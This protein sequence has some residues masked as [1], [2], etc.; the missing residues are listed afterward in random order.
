VSPDPH[1]G[2]VLSIHRARTSPRFSD[3]ELAAVA[4]LG[5]HVERSLRLS[6]RLFDAELLNVGLGEALARVDI[7]VFVI[8]SSG[9]VTL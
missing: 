1:L 8:D 5:R 3:S 4:R 7:G 9:R 6:S 2:V